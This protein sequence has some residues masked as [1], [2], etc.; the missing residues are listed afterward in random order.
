MAKYEAGLYK[1]VEDRFP[2]VM[3]VLTEKQ[4]ITDDLDKLMG[5]ALS[6]YGDEFADTIK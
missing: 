3:E 1:F 4:E 2:Q 5:E 6:A